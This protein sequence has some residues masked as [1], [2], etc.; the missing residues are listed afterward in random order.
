MEIIVRVNLRFSFGSLPF[1]IACARQHGILT[2]RISLK[3]TTGVLT[4]NT[5]FQF[6]L[7]TANVTV[8]NNGVTTASVSS[9]QTKN[10]I[11][12]VATKL[13]GELALPSDIMG[14]ILDVRMVDG[15]VD[16]Q[17]A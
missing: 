8:A 1:D 14:K 15:R 13:T 17:L 9:D 16:V 6:A 2:L 12:V 11:A 5:K 7:T 3:S 4:D 10:Q